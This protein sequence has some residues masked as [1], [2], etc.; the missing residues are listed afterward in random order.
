MIKAVLFDLGGTLHR[1]T[2]PPGRGIWFAN[3]IIDRLS[4]YGIELPVGPEEFAA[5]LPVN[6]EEYKANEEVCKKPE[7]PFLQAIL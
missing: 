3:R 2:V 6:A 5:I 4:D 1:G 7:K